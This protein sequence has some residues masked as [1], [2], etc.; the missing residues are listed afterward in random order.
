MR[1]ITLFPPE[2]TQ[3]EATFR[4]RVEP[5]TTLYRQSQFTLRFPESAELDLARV[6]ESLWW[7]IMLICLHS[8]WPLL[9]PCRVRLPIKLR[10]G[11]AECWSRL[12][13][14]YVMT[15]EAYRGTG[16]LARTVEIIDDGPLLPP[17]PPV[18]DTGRC[19]TAFSSGKDSL[20]HVGL[21]SELTDRPVLVATTSDMPQLED[22]RT[23]R[24][25]RVFE[26]VQRRRDVV[27]IEV[28]TDYRT[29]FDHGFAMSLGYPISVNELTDTF[30]YTGALLAVGAAL[31]VTHFFLAAEAAMSENV[32][33]DG[34][35]IQM[36]LCMFSDVTIG[37]LQSLLRPFGFSYGSLILPLHRYHIQTMVWTRYADLS[38]LQYSCWLV[39][40]NE[41]AC[42]R[43][44]KC[45]VLA[46]RAFA[47]GG[48]TSRIGVDWVIMLN[49]FINWKPQPRGSLNRPELPKDILYSELD[50]QVARDLISSPF[51]K[52]AL[53]IF[54]D[55]PLSYLTYRGWRALWAYRKMRRQAIA[56]NPG[57]QPGYRPDF[58]KWVDPLL[59]DKIEAIFA[60]QFV[61]AKKTEYE[62]ILARSERLLNWII[63][64]L[65]EDPS[66]DTRNN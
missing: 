17:P 8:Q 54:R 44:V 24:R 31:G 19:A 28:E 58:L 59:R 25:R 33:V 43:C 40:G 66:P 29:N 38:D 14:S 32:E 20:A 48:Q 39:K 53:T 36:V 10:P 41:F 61:P 3:R 35:I 30:V 37:A 6:P 62:G 15:W 13:D 64:P 2:I 4:W 52:M 22:H 65:G 18:K 1:T 60:A 9:R 26:D 56:L 49:E 51:R 7:T 5:E 50:A 45:L 55:A 12:M 47:L 57:P 27:F 23:P 21:L 16:D 46:I 42:N 63:E 11:E 34:R